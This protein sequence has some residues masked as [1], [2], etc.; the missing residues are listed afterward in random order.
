MRTL[1][2]T[3]V[4]MA[5][6]SG[7]LPIPRGSCTGPVSAAVKVGEYDLTDYGGLWFLTRDGRLISTLIDMSGG[8]WRARTP[9]GRARTIEVPAGVEHP[10]RYVAEQST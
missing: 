7:P 9:E 5:P 4:D 3:V 8:T 10:P 2:D 6:I 1:Q